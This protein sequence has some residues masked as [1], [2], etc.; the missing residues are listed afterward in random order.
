MA[1]RTAPH[2]SC[3]G[4]PAMPCPCLVCHQLHKERAV[5]GRIFQALPNFCLDRQ[6]NGHHVCFYI[7]CFFIFVNLRK[8]EKNSTNKIQKKTKEANTSG[9]MDGHT[10]G[11]QNRPRRLTG[12]NVRT[13]KINFYIFCFF[14][15]VN[16]REGEKNPKK[17]KK[18]KYVRMDGRTHRGVAESTSQINE[19][20]RQ[21]TENK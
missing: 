19:S 21:D 2:S 18:S 16:L 5:T 1:P 14:I 8:G 15:F 11:L 17:K 10:K 13:R 6:T 7:F 3:P 20:E 9:W 12:Q 4:H